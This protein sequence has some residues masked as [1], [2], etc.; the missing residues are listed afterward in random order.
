MLVEEHRIAVG[1]DGDEARR[2]RGGFFWRG[3]PDE[4]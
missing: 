1:V 4:D 2:A 3:E